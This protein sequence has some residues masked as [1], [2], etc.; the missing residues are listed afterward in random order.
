MDKRFELGGHKA[1]VIARTAMKCDIYLVS[2]IPEHTV[3]KMFLIPALSPQ[4][5]LDAAL[6]KHGPKAK[7]LV[8]PFGGMVLPKPAE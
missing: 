2:E 3:K 1:S 6:K 5:A 7:V 4:E 8:S